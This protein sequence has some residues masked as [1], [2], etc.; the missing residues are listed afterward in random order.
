MEANICDICQYLLP[1]PSA[2]SAVRHLDTCL[3]SAM[4]Q[5]ILSRL[6]FTE[7]DGEVVLLEYNERD[8]APSNF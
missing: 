6:G 7:T 1:V 5:K 3:R 8:A 4:T 2:P